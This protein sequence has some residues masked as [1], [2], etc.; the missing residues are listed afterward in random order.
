MMRD[1]RHT[2]NLMPVGLLSIYLVFLVTL[3]KDRRQKALNT[4]FNFL[5]R[6]SE[7]KEQIETSVTQPSLTYVEKPWL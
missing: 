1:Y 2:K 6:D 3:E 7:K 4:N 5:L